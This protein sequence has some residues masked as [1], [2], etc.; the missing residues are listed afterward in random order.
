MNIFC[1]KKSL[2]IFFW[3]V[4]AVNDKGRAIG[5]WA[6]VRTLQFTP[7]DMDP[8]TILS[9]SSYGASLSWKSPRMENGPILTYKIY[10]KQSFNSS[11]EEHS[12]TVAGDMLSTVISDLKAVTTYTVYIEAQNKVRNVLIKIN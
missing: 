1:V 11:A 10:Y 9:T 4:V 2:F 12:L 6:E 8:P 7:K 3:Q 5:D